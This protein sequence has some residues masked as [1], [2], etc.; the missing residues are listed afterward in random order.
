MEC[1][2]M[3]SPPALEICDLS[4]GYSNRQ[5]LHRVSMRVDRGE[6]FG[7]FG[8]NGAGK[9]TLIRT[10]CGRLK[11][12]AGKIAV[13]GQE[14]RQGVSGQ[15]GLVPQ[16]IALYPHLTILENLQVFGRLSG[17]SSATTKDAIAEVIHQAALADRLHQAVEHLS[18][19]WKRRVNIAAAVLHRPTL[20]IL[21]EPMV[22]VD[23]EARATLQDVLVKVR[24]SGVGILLITHD[25]QQA[26][27]L[28]SQIG[29]LYN[30]RVDLQGTPRRLLDSIF[31]TQHE[32]IIEMELP[33]SAKDQ[34]V[35]RARG[36]SASEGGRCWSV[37]S[38][39]PLHEVTAYLHTSAVATKEVRF[40]TPGLESLF[41]RLANQSNAGFEGHSS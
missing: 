27:T 18:G 33:V 8:Q 4:A 36:F 3:E 19:G 30:G 32:I 17:L 23:I 34:E 39:T 9:T 7:L 6:I 37:I 40:R 25:L 41:L 12:R 31:D 16:E 22:G 24:D 28:C 15:I 35:F 1:D 29:F 10:I 26:E 13:N 11:P 38:D 21:D 2:L 14:I 20:L 5:I